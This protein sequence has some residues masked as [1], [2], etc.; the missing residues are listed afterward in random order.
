M[1]MTLHTT[2]PSHHTNSTSAISQ[3]L[4]TQFWWNFKVRFLWTFRT[5]SICH[6]DICQGNICP[7]DIC[8]YQEYLSS[9][10][11]DFDETLKIGSWEHLEQIQTVMVTFIRKHLSPQHLYISG[12]SQLL[13]TRFWLNFE[14]RL[15]RQFL[16]DANCHGDICP[17]KICPCQQ[18]F[19]LY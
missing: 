18:Y 10:C 14:G 3:L 1:K 17:G 9:N 12:I 11:P 19:S 16:T 13:L 2:P 6:G 4:V 5:D 8:P 15:L 7:G